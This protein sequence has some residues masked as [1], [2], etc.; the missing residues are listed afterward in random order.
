MTMMLKQVEAHGSLLLPPPWS[1]EGGSFLCLFVHLVLLV[2]LLYLVHLALRVL[3][4]LLSF[5]PL[6]AP[7][8]NNTVSQEE[9]ECSHLSTAPPPSPPAS[10]SPT[11][12]PFQVATALILKHIRCFLIPGAPTLDPELWTYSK[13]FYYEAGK[14]LART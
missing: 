10:G 13:Q 12:P 11:S 3:L 6:L 7:L 14:D 8:Q 2:L 4:A 5:C 9:L 1:D